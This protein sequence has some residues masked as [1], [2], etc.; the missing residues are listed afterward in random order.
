[1]AFRSISTPVHTSDWAAG[2]TANLPSGMQVGD[3][4]LCFIIEDRETDESGA[5]TFTGWTQLAHIFYGSDLENVF[6][7]W[8]VATGSDPTTSSTTAGSAQTSAYIGAWSGRVGTTPTAVESF[9]ST[10]ANSPISISAT[11]ITAA[12]GDD[13][14]VFY[15]LD[16]GAQTDTW[17][18]GTV[19]N[20][21]SQLTY[22]ST[23]WDSSN[24]QTRDNVAVGATG[25]LDTTATRTGGAANAAWAAIVVAMAAAAV[26]PRGMGNHYG[27]LHDSEDD[28]QSELDVRNW[29]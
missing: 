7:Y 11:G 15:G 26:E 8:R 4:L 14:A 17:S 12:Q 19:T 1:M 6:V 23:D 13:I 29:V 2:L 27:L 18:Y 9:N 25:T 22:N 24:V 16:I 10:A 28:F 3:L 5:I 21:T 20:Y